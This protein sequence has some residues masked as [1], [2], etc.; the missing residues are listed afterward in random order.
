MTENHHAMGSTSNSGTAIEVIRTPSRTKY[1]RNRIRESWTSPSVFTIETVGTM[2]SSKV[3]NNLSD[4]AEND[5]DSKKTWMR[6]FVEKFWM[7]VCTCF[8]FCPD[9]SR[10]NQCVGHILQVVVLF[11]V[12]ILSSP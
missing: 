4:F 3:A 7:K 11:V 1:N 9:E 8:L 12:Y 6:Y 10:E 5:D 2:D